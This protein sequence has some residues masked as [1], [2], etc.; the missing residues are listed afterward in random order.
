MSLYTQWTD[1]VVEY[2]KTI[3]ENAFGVDNSKL[4]TAFYKD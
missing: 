2:V 3:G 4:D 1:M